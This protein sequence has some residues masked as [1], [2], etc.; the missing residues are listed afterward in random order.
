MLHPEQQVVG[1]YGFMAAFAEE[2]P[3]TPAAMSY[4][5]NQAVGSGEAPYVYITRRTYDRP[6]GAVT[7]TCM[8]GPEWPHEG[9]YDPWAP[10]PGALL[11]VVDR[12]APFAQRARP[13]GQPYDFHWHGLMGYMDGMVRVIGAAPGTPAL[14]YNLG[15]NGVGFLPSIHGGR[16]IAR[17][18]GGEQL[19][20]SIFDPR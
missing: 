7:L 17:L 15:C 8:G 14:L 2:Q 11:D 10:F 13:A 18:L 4:I 3:R 1:T 19:P 20:R 9:V 5:R 16:Q 6:G 12:G